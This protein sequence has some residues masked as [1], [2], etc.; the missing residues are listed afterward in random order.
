MS[1]YLREVPRKLE[2]HVGEFLITSQDNFESFYIDND[3]TSFCFSLGDIE[4]LIN[5]LEDI[6]KCYRELHPKEQ[7]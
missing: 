2:Y 1:I 5:C 6:N 3:V 7:E 4:K